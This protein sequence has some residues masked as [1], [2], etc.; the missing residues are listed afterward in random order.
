MASVRY[1]GEATTAC[2]RRGKHRG[3]QLTWARQGSR[4][5]APLVVGGSLRD[6][7]SLGTLDRPALRASPL[8]ESYRM[9]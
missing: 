9:Q 5:G 4:Q 1:A 3:G 6:A 7:S 8:F 2:M